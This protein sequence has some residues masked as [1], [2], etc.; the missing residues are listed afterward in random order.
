MYSDKARVIC[1]TKQTVLFDSSVHSHVWSISIHK[2]IK[3]TRRS[4]N[5]H[6]NILNLESVESKNTQTGFKNRYCYLEKE[7][8]R[9]PDNG[10]SICEKFSTWYTKGYGWVS[11]ATES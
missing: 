1:I 7:S 2:L 10:F 4:K 11:L 3:F 5:I 9:A 8:S 6:R